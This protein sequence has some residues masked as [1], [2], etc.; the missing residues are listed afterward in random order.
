MYTYTQIPMPHESRL[1][2]S[3]VRSQIKR[4]LTQTGINAE[5]VVFRNSANEVVLTLPPSRSSPKACL[6]ASIRGTPYIYFIDASNARVGG[7][8]GFEMLEKVL[9]ECVHLFRKV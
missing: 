1:S 4:I 8:V 3:D 9:R 6:V 7:V 2:I 5:Q